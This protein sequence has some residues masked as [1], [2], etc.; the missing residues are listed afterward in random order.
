M[1][2]LKDVAFWA[3][4]LIIASAT[5]LILGGFLNKIVVIY[6]QGKMPVL[7]KTIK[8]W[9]AVEHNSKSGLHCVLK[10]S[11]RLKFLADKYI[12]SEYTCSIGD[13]FIFFSILLFVISLVIIIIAL[14]CGFL[15]EIINQV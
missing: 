13:L 12:I 14:C 8:K 11:T 3:S 6:N 2:I 15:K 9:K 10:K 4:V 7:C 5:F 1:S